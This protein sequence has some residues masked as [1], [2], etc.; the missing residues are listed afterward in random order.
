MAKS[1][2]QALAPKLHTQYTIS[3]TFLPSTSVA[4]PLLILSLCI[5]F[6]TA[7]VHPLAKVSNLRQCCQVLPRAS[8]SSPT[9][10]LLALLAQ[11][12]L[13]LPSHPSCV[14]IQ[15][16]HGP[17]LGHT[18][19]VA[20]PGEQVHGHHQSIRPTMAHSYIRQCVAHR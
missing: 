3:S 10:S 4:P 12:P 7:L 20:Q 2:R 17:H 19:D 13:R 11:A 8:Q 1:P 14:P 5:C 9:S 18:L 6:H 16:P 15:Q